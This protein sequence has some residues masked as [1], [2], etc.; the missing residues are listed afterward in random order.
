MEI[1]KT[2]IRTRPKIIIKV[3]R[4]KRMIIKTAKMKVNKLKRFNK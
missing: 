4:T 1:I 3:E 2:K